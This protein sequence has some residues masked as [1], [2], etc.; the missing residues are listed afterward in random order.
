[1]NNKLS[2][3]E[4]KTMLLRPALYNNKEIEI[5]IDCKNSCIHRTE[6]TEATAIDMIPGDT[7]SIYVRAFFDDGDLLGEYITMYMSGNCLSDFIEK[8]GISN[9]TAKLRV[10]VKFIYTIYSTDNFDYEEGKKEEII[11]CKLLEILPL[12]DKKSLADTQ[13]HDFFADGM[14]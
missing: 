8:V 10:K 1:M 6:I 4:F 14:K 3:N 7:V 12:P 13:I 5:D 9:I 11:A 2:K